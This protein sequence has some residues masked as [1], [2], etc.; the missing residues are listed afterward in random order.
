VVIDGETVPADTLVF[1]D[2]QVPMPFLLRGLGL[3][4]GRP[5]TPAPVDADGRSP[6]PGLW[7]AGCCV[8]ADID[9]TG[10]AAD[11]ARVAGH[12][13]AALAHGESVA[14]A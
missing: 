4:D 9:H 10:C 11:G 12:I 8:H 5:G 13:V 14:R 6:L 1:A 3:V 7:A 2:R